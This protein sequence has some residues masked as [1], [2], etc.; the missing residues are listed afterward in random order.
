MDWSKKKL[1]QLM[2]TYGITM[3]NPLQ[4]TPS[5]I[6]T[7]LCVTCYCSTKKPVIDPPQE[8]DLA[9]KVCYH[10]AQLDCP[11]GYESTCATYLKAAQDSGLEVDTDCLLSAGNKTAARECGSV[12]CD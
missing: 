6:F 8:D 5:L 11:E 10:L 12:E 9:A 2:T 3:K 7:I 4:I 1:Y